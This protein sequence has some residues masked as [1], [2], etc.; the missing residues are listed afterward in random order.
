MGPAVIGRSLTARGGV[1]QAHAGFDDVQ[2]LAGQTLLRGG[3]VH[4]RGARDRLDAPRA[5]R[6][7]FGGV[8]VVDDEDVAESGEALGD[9]RAAHVLAELGHELGGGAAQRPSPHQGAD[10]DAGPA[11]V[12]HAL[13]DSGDGK[14]GRD[15]DH[16][17]RGTEDDGVGLVEAR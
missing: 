11:E 2:H 9:A 1:F 5:H 8:F 3:V 14:N 10:G 13:A 17:V 7:R 15:A 12:R 4:D 6:V 16:G